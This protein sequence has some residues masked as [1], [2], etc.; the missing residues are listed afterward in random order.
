MDSCGHELMP[1]RFKAVYAVA[2]P[3]HEI[4][5]R[6]EPLFQAV[7]SFALYKTAESP[8]GRHQLEEQGLG[9]RMILK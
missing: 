5:L 8:K 7:S 9:A 1:C 2:S 6:T 3:E 4:T